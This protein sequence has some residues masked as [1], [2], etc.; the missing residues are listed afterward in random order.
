M[1]YFLEVPSLFTQ[2]Y[3]F[4]EGLS[5]FLDTNT[6]KGDQ[7]HLKNHFCKLCRYLINILG[8]PQPGKKILDFIDKKQKFL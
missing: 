3:S 8:N 2:K 4:L 5:V 1:L 7:K 6:D